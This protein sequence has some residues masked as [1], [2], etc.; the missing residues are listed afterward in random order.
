MKELFWEFHMEVV[1]IPIEILGEI[2]EALD[3]FLKKSFE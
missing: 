2:H 3:E 1:K